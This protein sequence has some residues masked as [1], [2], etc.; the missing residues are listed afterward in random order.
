MSRKR[1]TSV[2]SRCTG[3]GMVSIA[4]ACVPNEDLSSYGS[5]ATEATAPSPPPIIAGT[6]ITSQPPRAP[7]A[8]D[9]AAGEMAEGTAPGGGAPVALHADGGVAPPAASE[10]TGPDASPP[11]APSRPGALVGESRQTLDVA[12][13]ERSFLYYAPAGLDPDVP[14]PVL[15]VAHGFEETAS[16]MVAITGFDTI[17][18]REGF[19][20]LYPEGQGVVPWNIGS[21]VCQGGAR[22]VASASSDDSA[23]IDAMLEFVSLDRSVDPAH[24]FMSGLASGGYLV[25]DLACRRSDIRAVVAHSGGSHALEPCVAAQKPVLLLHGSED[26]AVPVACSS[27]ARDRWAAHNGCDTSADALEVL[28]GVCEVSLGCPASGQVTLCTFEGMGRGWAGGSAQAASFLDFE[29]A[30]ELSWRFFTTF[31]W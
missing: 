13:V 18:D 27:E 1:R 25:N 4:A 6:A 11:A 8:A 14:A 19:V 29:S 15:I 16:E 7:G 31:A 5:A 23:F 10:A 3:V 24:I 22:P 12:G 30:S 2:W 20:V 21:G 28:G 17:A 26:A 9:D